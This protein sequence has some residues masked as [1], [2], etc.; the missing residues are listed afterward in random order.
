[1][2]LRKEW[3]IAAI[4]VLSCLQYGTLRKNN[5]WIFYVYVLLV[6]YEWFLLLY[7]IR[8]F[9]KCILGLKVLDCSSI[10]HWSYRTCN[11][12]HAHYRRQDTGQEW[13]APVNFLVDLEKNVIVTVFGCVTVNRELILEE[14]MTVHVR[15]LVLP[16][17]C[18]VVITQMCRKWMNIVVVDVVHRPRKWSWWTAP[19]HPIIV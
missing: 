9:Q 14:E 15:C 11:H 13:P 7:V 12:L 2:L 16:P 19:P 6:Y 3:F 8:C 4:T 1:M 10:C 18:T 5:W 17:E